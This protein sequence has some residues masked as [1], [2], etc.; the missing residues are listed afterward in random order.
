VEKAERENGKMRRGEKIR[1]RRKEFGKQRKETI[2]EE[3][4][5]K[6]ERGKK[7]AGR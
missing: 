7:M 5:D 3:R 1:C 2:D 4:R 6:L